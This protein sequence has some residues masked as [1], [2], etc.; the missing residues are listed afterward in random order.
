MPGFSSFLPATPAHRQGH[1]HDIGV[2]ERGFPFDAEQRLAL[3]ETNHRRGELRAD[4]QIDPRTHRQALAHCAYCFA[5]Y[6]AYLRDCVHR[7]CSSSWMLLYIRCNVFGPL[8]GDTKMTRVL[9]VLLCAMLC[10]GC[11]DRHITEFRPMSSDNEY[12][13]YVYKSFADAFYP[14]NSTSAESAR[15]QWL[16]EWMKDNGLAGKPY[17]ITNRQAF[18][19]QTGL[20]G[21]LYDI[22]Y[23]VRVKK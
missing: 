10:V 23:D 20:I 21:T 1:N 17:E 5:F 4:M 18:H 14:E 7:A 12:T 19:K 13:Y 11:S 16:E 22:Y 3:A 9:F 6:S 8:T 2:N 15:K